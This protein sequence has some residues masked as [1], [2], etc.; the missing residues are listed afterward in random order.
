MSNLER[1]REGIQ[2]IF[3]RAERE[4]EKEVN[5]QTESERERERESWVRR[6]KARYAS[7][8]FV[9]LRGKEHQRG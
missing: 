2:M 5:W 8:S 1:L 3:G 4:R 9:G 7:V 6:E